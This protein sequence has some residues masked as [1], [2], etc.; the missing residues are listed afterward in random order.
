MAK[1]PPHSFAACPPLSG[2]LG[3]DEEVT[4][5]PRPQASR[6]QSEANDG[7]QVRQPQA[8]QERPVRVL[9]VFAGVA[10]KADIHDCLRQRLGERLVMQ[11]LDTQRGQ[12]HELMQ[13]GLWHSI[14]A[15][16]S[17]GSFDVTIFSPPCSTWS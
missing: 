10:R 12:G 1:E 8:T 16:I 15:S 14:R 4:N 3:L 7:L 6:V 5:S 17:Q 9:Y 13:G 2:P 11:E